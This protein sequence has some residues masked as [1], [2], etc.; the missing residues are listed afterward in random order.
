MEIDAWI[1]SPVC[2]PQLLG[3]ESVEIFLNDSWEAAPN[4]VAGA[5]PEPGAI[6][7]LDGFE[8]LLSGACGAGQGVPSVVEDNVARPLAGDI[9]N[10]GR[11][12]A[13]SEAFVR[14]ATLLLPSLHRR[15]DR[16][17]RI[18]RQIDNALLAHGIPLR[19]AVSSNAYLTPAS[20]QGFGAHYDDHCVVIL[21]LSG[22]K[23]W[24]VHAP[25]P[26]LPIA[27]CTQV[28]P[29]AS[30]AEKRME[31][32]LEAGDIL[33]IPRGF[34]HYARSEEV[35]SL[36]VTLGISSVQ[37]GA[38]LE[39]LANGV[40]AFRASIRPTE[41]DGTPA[42]RV[43]RDRLIPWL[44]QTDP[45]AML[46]REL[47]RSLSRLPPLPGSRLAAWAHARM[48]ADTVL[49][50]APHV[51]VMLQIDGDTAVLHFPGGPLE[52]PLAMEETLEFVADAERFA[53][54]DIPAGAANFDRMVLAR[55]LIR[56]GMVT[57]ASP[58][59]PAPAPSPQNEETVDGTV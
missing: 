42:A 27:R 59:A 47:G 13:A 56:S 55:L 21:Q 57:P 54:S 43:F 17:G 2:A 33:Y 11:L 19:R 10:A 23:H 8:A 9:D 30:L 5:L 22:S 38:L 1:D 25:D 16:L 51:L 50:R 4:Y 7:D 32:R 37:W 45:A 31:I 14:G 15:H 49:S 26:A 12:G 24:V 58:S 34:P 6:L 35:A 46:R 41:L 39:P 20:T 28:I 44:S 18:C 48:G 52:L 36:H 29:E 53:V 3:A 40:T